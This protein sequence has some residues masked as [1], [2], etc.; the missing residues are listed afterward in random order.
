MQKS[1]WYDSRS[2]ERRQHSAAPCL[3]GGR[4]GG[5]PGLWAEQRR[6]W[7]GDP[8]RPEKGGP[9]T[10]TVLLA[11]VMIK[12]NFFFSATSNLAFQE[13]MNNPAILF[14]WVKDSDSLDTATI[15]AEEVD[16]L[17]SLLT[18]QDLLKKNIRVH[19]Y[20]N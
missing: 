4:E 9:V 7:P 5:R 18:A 16:Q 11:T 13:T 3:V 6:A 12:T 19:S 20:S 1:Q 15:N 8:P 10:A 14:G 17:D 2:Q